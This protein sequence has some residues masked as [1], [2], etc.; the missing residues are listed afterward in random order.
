M[1]IEIDLEG[2]R[3]RAEK[4]FINMDPRTG[5]VHINLQGRAWNDAEQ[6]YDGGLT[7]VS[8]VTL[9]KADVKRISGALA[10]LV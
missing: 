7:N 1:R 2:N 5:K 4:V 10:L 3:E 8:W 9:T 6:V